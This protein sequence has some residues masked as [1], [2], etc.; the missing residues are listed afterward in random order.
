M[1]IK[2]DPWF[3][4][5][6]AASGVEMLKAFAKRSVDHDMQISCARDI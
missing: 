2:L 4:C 3:P 5:L 6:M 1:E